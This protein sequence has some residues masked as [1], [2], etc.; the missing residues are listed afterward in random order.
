MKKNTKIYA[1]RSLKLDGIC[2]SLGVF[3]T[4][5]KAKDFLCKH[6][7]KMD[8]EI[9]EWT[10]N[11]EYVIDKTQDPY[12]VQFLGNEN[13]PISISIS[14]V[15]HDYNMLTLG[16]CEIIRIFDSLES[17]TFLV[18]VLAPDKKTAVK[19]ARVIRDKELENGEWKNEPTLTKEM[20]TLLELLAPN[21]NFLSDHYD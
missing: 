5:K 1:V 4:R 3:D 11:P 8:A 12:M 10:L 13:K 6:K 20:E 14:E 19:R 2:S 17:M 16:I 18:S 21:H 7:T 9:V 15:T